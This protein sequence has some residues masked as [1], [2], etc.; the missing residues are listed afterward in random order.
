MERQLSSAPLIVAIVLLL[1]MAYV[2]SYFALVVPHGVGLV[3][4]APREYT[5]RGPLEPYRMGG[6]FSEVIF[7]P[8]ERL[9][10]RIRQSAW[11]YGDTIRALAG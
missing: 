7:W 8:I 10:R 3:Q 1:L 5:V 11:E 2:G 9:D 4:V 6:R